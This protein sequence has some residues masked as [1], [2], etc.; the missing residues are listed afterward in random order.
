VKEGK[1]WYATNDKNNNLVWDSANEGTADILGQSLVPTTPEETIVISGKAA[2]MES[3]ELLSNFAAG[4]IYTGD[5]GAAT[6]SPVGAKL[7]WGIPFN[8]RPLALRGW[9]RYEPQAINRTSSAYSH[10][11]GQTDFCQIQI[12]LTTWSD[13]F[14]ISTGDNRF[15]D[16]SLKNKDIVAYGAI[17][18]QDNTTD[19][20]GNQNGYVRFTIPLEY[21]SLAQP[22]YIV[23]SGAASRYGDYFTGGLGSTMYLDE[24]ELVYDPDQLTAEEY[25]LVMKAIQ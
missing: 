12:F 15:V 3:G 5:F 6:I 25:E 9:Y 13:A 19:N 21:R 2:R 23:I 11:S 10:L 24:L 22:T 1:A 8:S 7:D 16:T 4:N 14:E 17:V 20:P 18:S